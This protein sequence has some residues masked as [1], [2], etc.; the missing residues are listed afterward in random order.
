MV[1]IPGSFAYNLLVTLGLAAA[2]HP[3][4][5]DFHLTILALPIVIAVHLPLLA[6][7]WCGKIPRVEGALLGAMEVVS[8]VVVVLVH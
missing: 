6:L 8:L 4:P 7:I 3:L 1:D 2:L 5:V